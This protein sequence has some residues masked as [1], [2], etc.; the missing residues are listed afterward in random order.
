MCTAVLGRVHFNTSFR[1]WS[2]YELLTMHDLQV[3]RKAK[4]L[5]RNSQPHLRS[6]ED[7][8]KISYTGACSSPSSRY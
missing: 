5:A 8:D 3:T 6:V 4:L 1:T 2:L 7:R